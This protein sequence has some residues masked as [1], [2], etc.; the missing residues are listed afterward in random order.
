M[1]KLVLV[2]MLCAAFSAAPL[3]A[4]SAPQTQKVAGTV[5]ANVGVTGG[6]ALDA[7]LTGR[8][9]V[10]FASADDIAAKTATFLHGGLMGWDNAGSN[11]DRVFVTSN[12]LNVSVQNAALA[13]TG[14]FWQAIQPVSNA[15]TFAVQAAQSGTW[16][17][18][19][20]NTANTTPWIVQV[21]PGAT[22]GAPSCNLQSA[23]TT[24]ATN[25]KASDGTLQGYELINTTA[26][27]V[28]LRLYNLAAAPTCSS[29]T[30]FVRSIPIP[31]SVNGA[32]VVRDM[33]VGEAFGTGIGFCLTGGGTPTDNTN[34]VTGVYLSILY[35]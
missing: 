32:G 27:L 6:L 35:K 24:N 15:G 4:A 25:C 16:T 17:V 7:T 30:G 2:L 19:P 33:N 10:A 13:V 12:A 20:G 18:Q 9:P 23:A 34:A 26:T 29:A 5:T 31:S 28:F 1:K 14:T 8:F 22:N 11:W 3:W 21:V